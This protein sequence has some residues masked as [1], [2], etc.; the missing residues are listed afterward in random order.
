MF[1]KIFCRDRNKFTIG[2]G[3]QKIFR[4]FTIFLL[5]FYFIG[6]KFTTA[7]F[8]KINFLLIIGSPKIKVGRCCLI[9]DNSMKIAKLRIG[10]F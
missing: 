4:N 5:P 8:Y 3:R 10:N 9:I 2:I 6:P 1:L 7:F